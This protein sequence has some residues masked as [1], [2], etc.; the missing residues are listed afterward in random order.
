MN[1][2]YTV[3]MSI[4]KWGYKYKWRMREQEGC[5]GVIGA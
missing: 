4:P 3:I 1:S 5:A 2:V